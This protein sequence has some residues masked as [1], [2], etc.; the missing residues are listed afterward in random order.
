MFDRYR[1]R[2]GIEASFRLANRARARTTTRD[3]AVRLVLF[4]IALLIENEWIWIKYDMLSVPHRGRAGRIVQDHILR[5]DTFL[6]WIVHALN[7]ALGL[8]E[9]VSVEVPA[10]TPRKRRTRRASGG[11]GNY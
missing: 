8:V 5:F 1:E 3:P 4:G 7:I 11:G 10:T 2:F 6:A 9:E